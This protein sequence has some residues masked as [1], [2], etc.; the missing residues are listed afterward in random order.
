M[1]ICSTP[2]YLE[3]ISISLHM[4]H[5]L[6][7]ALTSIESYSYSYESALTVCHYNTTYRIENT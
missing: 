1:L 7:L 6:G 2:E 3:Q 4:H 5:V